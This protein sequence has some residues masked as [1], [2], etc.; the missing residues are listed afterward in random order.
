L[1]D[2]AMGAPM[3]LDSFTRAADEL[4]R[5][6]TPAQLKLLDE[7]QRYAQALSRRVGLGQTTDNMD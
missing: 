2:P 5:S 7:W 1:S 4:S 3:T 6:A